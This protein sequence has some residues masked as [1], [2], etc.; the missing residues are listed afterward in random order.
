MVSQYYYPTVNFFS[1]LSMSFPENVRVGVTPITAILFV[2]IAVGKKCPFVTETNILQYIIKF[3]S[4]SGS[5]SVNWCIIL[6]SVHHTYSSLKVSRQYKDV[7]HKY[8]QRRKQTIEDLLSSHQHLLFFRNRQITGVLFVMYAVGSC[9]FG[10][11]T[12][13]IIY[14][15]T[16]LETIIKNSLGFVK[17]FRQKLEDALFYLPHFKFNRG[18]V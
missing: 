1:I 9:K 4:R 12:F 17:L 16:I 7:P 5:S 2:N 10:Y 13:N 11:V 8:S 15:L 18:S 6:I 14:R 3:V